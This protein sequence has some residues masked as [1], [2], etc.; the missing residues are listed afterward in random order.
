MSSAV[1]TRSRTE[2]AQESAYDPFASAG[3]ELGGSSAIYAKFNGNSGEMSYGSNATEIDEGS[4]LVADVAGARRGW[5][6]WKDEKVVDEVMVPIVQGPPP[7]KH[8]LTDH[9]P[10]TEHE[11]G[12]KDGWSEQFAIDFRLLGEGHDGVQITYKTTTKSAMRPLGDLLKDYG[13]QYKNNPGALPIVTLEKGSYMPKEKKHGKKYFPKFPIADWINEDDLVAQYGDGRRTAEGD[14]NSNIVEEPKAAA[15]K[16]VTKATAKATTTTKAQTAPAA[17]PE[18]DDEEAELLRQ[19]AEKRAA[20]A[21]AAA[22][23]E[24]PAE[25]AAPAATE[26][27]PVPTGER[28]ARRRSF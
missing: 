15:P 2:V 26:T 25:E 21:A 11:D 24:A 20:K 28:Q 16:Q 10:Y 14:E 8:E 17:E 23:A 3:N 1:A 22:A 12:T 13:R 9:G 19:L 7:G 6:C 27:K 18:V 4:E 5:I